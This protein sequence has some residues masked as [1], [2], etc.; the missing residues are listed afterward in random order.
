MTYAIPLPNARAVFLDHNGDPLVG[1]TVA[2][3]E[4]GTLTPKDTY[5]DFG[6][7]ITN[8]NPLTLDSLGSAV[9]FGIGRYRQIVKDSLGNQVWDNETDA[10]V[11]QPYEAGFYFI[12]APSA[13]DV[14]GLWNFTKYVTFSTNFAS[15]EGRVN[16]A[17]LSNISIDIKKNGSIIGE[18]AITTLGAV[19]FTTNISS[20]AFSPGDYMTWV[21]QSGGAASAAGIGATMLGSL[22]QP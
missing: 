16:T 9:I 14:I 11:D 2:F 6:A 22:T 4:P 5:Q 21:V 17:P 20:P 19:T 12:D 8:A 10:L 1:G 13:N 18:M 3:Y 7:T 15:S